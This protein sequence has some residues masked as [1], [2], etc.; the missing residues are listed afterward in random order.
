MATRNPVQATCSRIAAARKA[1]FRRDGSPRRELCGSAARSS[2]AGPP[3]SGDGLSADWPWDRFRSPWRA[4]DRL[5][6]RLDMGDP[7]VGHQVRGWGPA[8]PV[9]LT[10]RG[11]DHFGGVILNSCFKAVS[12]SNT[13]SKSSRR[14]PA[15]FRI[16]PM[17]IRLNT[18]SP[19]SPV[20]RMPQ[21][22]NTVWAM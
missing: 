18:I 14:S 9:C 5:L 4:A 2:T 1:L 6:R 19:K 21:L 15:V 22:F 7:S 12:K 3:A 8:S 10:N 11:A 17:R 20:V 16:C 13:S